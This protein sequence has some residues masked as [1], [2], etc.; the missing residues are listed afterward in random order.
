[1]T[2]S[3]VAVRETLRDNV[4]ETLKTELRREKRDHDIKSHVQKFQ[5]GDV[6]YLVDN[7]RENKLKPVFRGPAIIV[8]KRTP[9]L[10]DVMTDNSRVTTTN[11]DYIKLCWDKDIP[12]W[13]Q[14]EREAV[15]SGTERKY[16]ICNRPYMDIPMVQCNGCH[17]WFHCR[18]VNLTIN[19]ANKLA[20]FICPWCRL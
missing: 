3:F 17:E 10:F 14:R 4:R 20:R 9:C 2:A 7:K 15:L 12:R 5:E 13:I 16:C 11:H 6:V 8:K 19:Q 18:C 1:M